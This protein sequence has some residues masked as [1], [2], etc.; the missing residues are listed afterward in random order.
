MVDI[1]LT[2][3]CLSG[4][5]YASH[6]WLKIDFSYTPLFSVSL[7]GIL[8]FIFAVSNQL[9]IGTRVLIYTG[10]LLSA[11]CGIDVWKNKNRDQL[12][13]P[14]KIFMIFVLLVVLSYLITLGMK[15]T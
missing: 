5:I 12:F 1:V 10:Y 11:V 15:F 3:L 6:R 13:I 9:E 8:L 4:F 14:F 7:M 2:I